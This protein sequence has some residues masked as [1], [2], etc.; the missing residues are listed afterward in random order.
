MGT[1]EGREML[2]KVPSSTFIETLILSSGKKNH[3]LKKKGM[4][5]RKAKRWKRKKEKRKK[6][7]KGVPERQ[8]GHLMLHVLGNTVPALFKSSH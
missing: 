8:A 1:L 6:S 5:M 4:I 3:D 7:D 2:Q